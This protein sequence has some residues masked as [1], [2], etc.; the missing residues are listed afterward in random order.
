MRL[1]MLEVRS[2][3]LPALLF[4]HSSRPREAVRIGAPDEGEGA[5]EGK[6]LAWRQR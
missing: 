1:P 4:D 2:Q 6:Q 3:T 5:D